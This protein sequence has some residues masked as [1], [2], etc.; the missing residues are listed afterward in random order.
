MPSFSLSQGSL[1]LPPWT[2]GQGR[3]WGNKAGWDQIST[4][5]LGLLSHGLPLCALPSSLKPFSRQAGCPAAKEQE[6]LHLVS[7][8]CGLVR[9]RC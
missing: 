1:R 6:P 8:G 7:G 3:G 9:E 4:E 2:R 5:A